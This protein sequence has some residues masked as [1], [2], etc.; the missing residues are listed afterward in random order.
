M[1]GIKYVPYN[2]RGLIKLSLLA[3]LICAVLLMMDGKPQ[4][5]PVVI[6]SFGLICIAGLSYRGYLWIGEDGFFAS[7]SESNRSVQIPWSRIKACKFYDGGHDSPSV[8]ILFQN[9]DYTIFGKRMIAWNRGIQMNREG[10]H[11]L[12]D[13][14]LRKL[15]F[16]RISPEKFA[17]REVFGITATKEEYEM[18]R[19][20]WKNASDVEG[21]NEK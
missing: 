8:C 13:V 21:N 11:I 14:D 16:G 4:I 9:P 20:W 15:S 2:R 19:Q 6:I 18:I 5:L 7:V 10:R 3:V 12:C 17:A 1:N